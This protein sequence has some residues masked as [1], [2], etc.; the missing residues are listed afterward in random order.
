MAMNEIR[1]IN[2]YAGINKDAAANDAVQ[3][4]SKRSRLPAHTCS[5]LGSGTVEQSM[6]FSILVEP[7]KRT[8][9]AAMNKI[10]VATRIAIEKSCIAFSLRALTTKIRCVRTRCQT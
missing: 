9:K 5:A 8:A 2:E 1:N 3:N 10:G 6:I 7:A 4:A